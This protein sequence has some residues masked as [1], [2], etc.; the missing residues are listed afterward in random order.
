MLVLQR[1]ESVYR[2]T[3]VMIWWYRSLGMAIGDRVIIDAKIECPEMIS[4]G[5][6]TVLKVR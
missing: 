5:C 6:D 4:I 2:N 1:L 3:Q